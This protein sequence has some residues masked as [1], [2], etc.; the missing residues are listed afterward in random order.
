MSQEQ[1][2]QERIALIL[3]N[4]LIQIVTQQSQ[5]EALH[6]ALAERDAGRPATGEKESSAKTA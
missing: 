5:I 4:Q 6:M 2:A 1:T 3:G